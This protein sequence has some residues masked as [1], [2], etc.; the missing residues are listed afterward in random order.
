M[1][2]VSRVKGTQDF[3]D[4]TLYNFIINEFEKQAHL[5]RFHQIAMPIIEHVELFKRSLGTHTDVVSKEMFVLDTK[6]D[7]EGAICLRPEATA[8]T[9][10]AFLEIKPLTPWKVYSIGPMFRYEQPQKGRYRQFHQINMEIIGSS[11][12]DQDVDLIT[13][14]DRLF[15]EKLMLNNYALHLNFLGSYDDRIAYQEILRIF[16]NSAV[17]LC[18]TC[19]QRKEK[20][21]MRIFDCK[22]ETCQ[23]IYSKAPSIINHLSKQSRTEWEQLQEHLSLMSVSYAYN[24]KLVRGLDYY[25][26]TVFEFVSNDL[27]SQNAFCGGGRYDRL[28]TELGDQQGGTPAVGAAIGLERLMLLVEPIANKLSLPHEASLYIIMPLTPEQNLLALLLSDTLHAANLVTDVFLDNDSLKSM[29]RRA[30]K[31]GAAYVLIIG[32]EEQRNKSVLV[33]N[34]MNGK[35]EQIAQ[36]D[37]VPYFKH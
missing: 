29:M 18:K 30:N 24:P 4:L 25:N 28:A 22:N 35:Q 20:N 2:T 21:I 37:L 33:K 36:I 17:G 32:D 19:E 3:V 27:G 6:K 11:A 31:M 7:P 15:H 8:Q 26:R 14:L 9:I 34:M 10:R 12:I 5:Y 23:E 13:M 16:L 1:Q